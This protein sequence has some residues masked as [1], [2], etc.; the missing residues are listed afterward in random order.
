MEILYAFV[1]HKR[2]TTKVQPLYNK[3]HKKSTE[4]NNQ[5]FGNFCENVQ[6]ACLQNLLRNLDTNKN[7]VHITNCDMFN[8]LLTLYV[9]SCL[10]WMHI[11]FPAVRSVLST[12]CQLSL[13]YK[14]KICLAAHHSHL[15]YTVCIQLSSARCL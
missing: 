6:N 11:F 9:L 1:F 4:E 13:T 2:Q 12:N 3:L 8:L 7:P 14:K 5:L 10:T 15:V